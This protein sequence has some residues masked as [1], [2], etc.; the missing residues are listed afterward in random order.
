M[1]KK[2]LEVYKAAD[3]PINIEAIIKEHNINLIKTDLWQVDWLFYKNTIWV[4]SILSKEKQRF[5][6]AHEFC[7]YLLKE[8]WFSKWIYHSKD[9]KEKRADK[10]ATELLLPAIPIYEAYREYW[11]IPTLSEMFG[12]PWKVIEMRLNNLLNN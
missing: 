12:V 4:N 2:V 3:I 9:L 1:L 8:T 6:I 11:N 5:T 10:F 7:H